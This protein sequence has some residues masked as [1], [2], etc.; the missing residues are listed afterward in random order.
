MRKIIN[1]LLVFLV[2]PA[3]IIL[4]IVL[5][6][7]KQYAIVYIGAAILACVP[8]FLR[9]ETRKPESREIVLIAILTALSVASRI[10]F[11]EVPSIKPV[12][13]IIIICAIAFGKETGFLIGSL[14]ALLS[15]IYFGQGAWTPFQML[16]WGIVGFVAG[17]LRKTIFFKNIFGVL[18]YGLLAGFLY[19]VIVDIQTV[20][21]AYR[22]FS[23]TKYFAVFVTSLPY[24][25]TYS[26]TNVIFLLLLYK[27]L[28]KK[29]MRIKD[30]YNLYGDN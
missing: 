15:N 9:F 29:L 16:A 23:F 24:T 3:F 21:I 22:T 19:S 4:G 5:L 20:L 8:F 18:V 10:L 6:K 26:V 27:P 12:T 17:M 2:I 7:A 25:L 1:Y 11:A 14:T 28:L 13:S 30:K